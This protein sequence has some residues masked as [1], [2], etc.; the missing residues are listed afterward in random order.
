MLQLLATAWVAGIPERVG[1]PRGHAHDGNTGLGGSG[2]VAGRLGKVRKVAGRKMVAKRDQQSGMDEDSG[3]G[4]R[5]YVDGGRG[6]EDGGVRAWRELRL[7]VMY[8]QKGQGERRGQTGSRG[9]VGPPR[10]GRGPGRR[11][12][13]RR[14]PAP[15]DQ[16][17]PINTNQHQSTYQPRGKR[18]VMATPGEHS[19]A[20]VCPWEQHQS[21][22]AAGRQCL[23][24]KVP[25]STSKCR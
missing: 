2:K 20:S 12:L 11:S 18:S 22:A 8:M 13:H 9:R 4:G 16:S 6:G 25:G 14:H 21:S 1:W 24:W 23:L 15:I 3:M 7:G 10:R 19:R 17:T 5:W